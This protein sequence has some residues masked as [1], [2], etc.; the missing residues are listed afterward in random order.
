[1]EKRPAQKGMV[2]YWHLQA[3]PAAVTVAHL[4]GLS[5]ATVPQ[6]HPKV[7]VY[8]QPWCQPRVH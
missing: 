3:N 1:M 4:F 5:L 6:T 2:S 8:G 7:L